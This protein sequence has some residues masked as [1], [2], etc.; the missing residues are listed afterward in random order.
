MTHDG[1]ELSALNAGLYARAPSGLDIFPIVNLTTTL[2]E[3]PLKAHLEA[4]AFVTGEILHVNG[5]AHA[6]RW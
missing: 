6:G 5:G 3:Q 2:A 1:Q 4:P